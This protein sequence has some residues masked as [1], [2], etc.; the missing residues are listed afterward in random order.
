VLQSALGASRYFVENVKF[1]ATSVDELFLKECVNESGLH[2]ME[3]KEHRFTPG[4]IKHGQQECGEDNNDHS[5]MYTLVATKPGR[6]TTTITA[7]TP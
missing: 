3:Y 2:L 6:T 1:P 5:G 7:C 4:E